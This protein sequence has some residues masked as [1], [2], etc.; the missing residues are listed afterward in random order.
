LAAGRLANLVFVV[1]NQCDDM[2]D[3]SVSTGDTWLKNNVPRLL[4]AVGPRGVVVL[5]WDEDDGS[6]SNRILTVMVGAPVKV[7]YVSSGT[8][9]HYTVL[10]TLCE[11]LGLQAFGAA[12]GKTPIGDAWAGSSSPTTHCPHFAGA[13]AGGRGRS[14]GR[15]WGRR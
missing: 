5:T 12:S 7:G 1:P 2:H 9:N 4:S 13:D 3:C 6:A 10:R 15:R 14:W 11:G 8:I